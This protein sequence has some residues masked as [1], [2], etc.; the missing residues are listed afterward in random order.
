MA[1]I[2]PN[3]YDMDVINDVFGSNPNRLPGSYITLNSHWEDRNIPKWADGSDY[4]QS[5]RLG[6]DQKLE[7]LYQKSHII[8]F[9]AVGKPWM[10]DTQKVMKLRPNAH[11]IL[12]DQWARWRAIAMQECPNGVIDHV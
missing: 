6:L 1:T 3:H 2:R 7:D 10:H 5:A 4:D 9:F 12:Y 8:H 11:P